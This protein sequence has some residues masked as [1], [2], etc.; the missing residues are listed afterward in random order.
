MR[1]MPKPVPLRTDRGQV[2][3]VIAPPP[4]VQIIG[5]AGGWIPPTLAN[6]VSGV[7]SEVT[8]LAAIAALA[9]WAGVPATLELV[10][11]TKR[12]VV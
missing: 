4:V 10:S 7:S 3:L 2:M 8:V 11:A 9:L 6:V 12:D 5:G 1:A